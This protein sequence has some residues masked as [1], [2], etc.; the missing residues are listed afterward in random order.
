MSKKTLIEI[1]EDYDAYATLYIHAV[2]RNTVREGDWETT[3]SVA[4]KSMKV[5][6]EELADIEKTLLEGDTLG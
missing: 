1:L 4:S 5:I 2:K 3:A 6:D